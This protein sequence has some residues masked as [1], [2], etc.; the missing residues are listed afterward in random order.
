MGPSPRFKIG[1]YYQRAGPLEFPVGPATEWQHRPGVFGPTALA[2]VPKPSQPHW[3]AR[4]ESGQARLLL[5][6]TLPK[7][8]TMRVTWQLGLRLRYRHT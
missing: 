4:S 6:L 8:R 3:Q 7:S 2:V 5:G 1:P